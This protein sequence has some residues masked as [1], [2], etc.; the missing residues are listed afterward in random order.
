MHLSH[1]KITEYTI[2]EE[3][4]STLISGTADGLLQ[5]L[6][7]HLSKLSTR[8]S[9]NLHSTTLQNKGWSL[10]PESEIEINCRS[11]T[12]NTIAFL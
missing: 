7:A 10:A 5:S 6:T 3:L 12:T 4:C 8:I 9:I 2:Y 1:S 11:S